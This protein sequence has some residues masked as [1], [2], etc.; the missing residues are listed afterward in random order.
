VDAPG[1]EVDL[2]K[3]LLVEDDALVSMNQSLV[4]KA[5][6]YDVVRALSGEKAIDAVKNERPP[7]DLVLMDIDLG[8][9][10]DGA[11]AAREILKIRDVPV[12]FLTSHSEREMV[13]RTGTT[14]NYG[15]VLKNSGESVL[16]ASI[17]MAFRLHDA[18]RA[19]R[20]SEEKYSKAFNVSPD[21]IN[22][23]RVSDGVYFAVNEGFTRITG[24]TAED[25]IGRSS[26][27]HDLNIWADDADRHRLV[28]G[29]KPDGQVVG[30]EARFRCKD[31]SIITG[32][33]SA[34]TLTINGE[35]CLLN[36]TRDISDRK[37]AER[38]LEAS[39]SALRSLVD[40]LPVAIVSLDRDN[41]VREW[42]PAAEKMFGWS[43]R[44]ML[45]NPY[46]LV[47]PH[48]EAEFRDS[49]VR[50]LR[51]ER[52]AEWETVRQARNGVLVDVRISTALIPD[53][54]GRGGDPLRIA[55][56]TDI[57]D[58]KKDQTQLRQLSRAVEQS[59]S[60]IV[61]TDL[62]GK[63]EYVNPR[64]TQLSG[65]TLEESIGKNPRILKSGATPPEEYS[66]LWETIKSGGEWSGEFHNRK[67]NGDLYWESAQISPIKD[68]NGVV[69]HFLA[70]K[71]D[72]TERKQ[73]ELHIRE[74]ETME[75]LGTLAGGVAHDFNNI[76]GI[77]LGHVS[78]L[79]MR[80]NENS[81]FEQSVRSINSAIQRGAG[82]VR[83]IL[84]YA[85]KTEV[86]PESI[87]VNKAI[88]DLS[89]MIQETFPRTVEI[90]LNLGE[91]IPIISMDNTQLHQ[92]LLNLCINARDAMMEQREGRAPGG[93]LTIRT[94]LVDGAVLSP[95]EGADPS[96]QYVEISVSDQGTGMTDATVQRIFEP[97]FTTKELGR[98]TGLGLSLVYGVVKTHG[99]FVDVDSRLGEGTVF[100]LYF[101]V[102]GSAAPGEDRPQEGEGPAE[103]RGEG[104]LIVEDEETLLELLESAF[105]DK[106][107]RV[108]L[109]SDGVRG[110]AAYKEHMKEI[111]V[112][113]TDF[114][115]PKA[116]GAA[117]LGS[118][119]ELNPSVKVI[120]ASGF[121][122]PQVRAN[123]VKKGVRALI[124]KPYGLSEVLTVVRRVID[125]AEISS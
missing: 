23:N 112:V 18:H 41:R 15:Y 66:R 11:E 19:L 1:A 39:N 114:G 93:K 5:E 113:V 43:A 8:K 50:I 2:K 28:E 78:L 104:V 71:E 40:T 35:E 101:P 7:V 13:S 119:Q 59:S 56:I 46:P 73:M 57:T 58:W 88:L 111:A 74:M 21:S 110:I 83:Q 68:P 106:G 118:L 116:D 32:L 22:I 125:G 91:Q 33:M 70:V 97:F 44:E 94:L 63:I 26:M 124:S 122:E 123:L 17:T 108:F 64:F 62:E 51:G 36:I 38:A 24:Y 98:G 92:A 84:T 10:M 105:L 107:Y 100:R 34:R 25:V 117:L 60:S 9:G 75:S 54:E 86:H 29:L 37:K 42:N 72:I 12:L 87:D 47:P 79:E 53:A 95:R 85:R 49:I 67:K 80:R 16:F 96:L 121:F 48:K 6:G 14:T 89:R 120:V 69:T 55:M 99:G 81:A 20:D 102:S 27:S 3:I 65:Y 76:L 4:L 52:L 61:I 90:I 30:L 82:L 31:G 77:I 103:G 109:A 115:L 45:G